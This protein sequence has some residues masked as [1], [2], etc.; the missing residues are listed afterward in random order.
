M[1]VSRIQLHPIFIPLSGIRMCGNADLNNEKK[2]TK[3]IKS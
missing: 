1:V 2:T 3:I